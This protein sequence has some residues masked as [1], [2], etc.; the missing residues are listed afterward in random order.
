[1]SCENC[2]ILLRCEELYFLFTG[3]CSDVEE[4]E[5]TSLLSSS[6][7]PGFFQFLTVSRERLT[8]S[9]SK[10]SLYPKASH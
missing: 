9:L 6:S 2:V 4:A 10:M 5:F 1:M 3:S 7:L 8:F